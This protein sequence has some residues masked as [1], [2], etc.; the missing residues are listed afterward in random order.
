M[1]ELQ[2]LLMALQYQSEYRLV[3]ES[4]ELPGKKQQQNK[5]IYVSH[6]LVI[7]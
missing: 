1:G 4:H 5:H 6:I 3:R 7:F 2:Y